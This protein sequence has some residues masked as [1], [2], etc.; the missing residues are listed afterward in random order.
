LYLIFL[1]LLFCLFFIF[2]L[3][4]L[5][6]LFFLFLLFFHVFLFFKY[7]PPAGLSNGSETLF[8]SANQTAYESVQA[9]RTVQ[10]YNLQ[11]RVVA[12]YNSLLAL[13]NKRSLSNALSSGAALGGGQG[14]MFWVYAFAFWYGG[15]LVEKGEM[16]LESTLMVFFAI[17]LATMGISQAQIAFPDVSKGSK[18]V[19]RVFR[20]VVLAVCC[21]AVLQVEKGDFY[22]ADDILHHKVL[23]FFIVNVLRRHC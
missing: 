4:F 17:L 2:C 10:S 16:D 14:V 23:C 20:G 3:F 9:L 13:P 7:S 11:G 8:D 19:A 15:T 12:I 22:C 18:A 5:F 21:S 1:F 6:F